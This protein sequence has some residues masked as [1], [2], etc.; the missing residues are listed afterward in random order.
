MNEIRS[1]FSAFVAVGLL[2]APPQVKSQQR[3]YRGTTQSV[4][5]LIHRIEDHTDL[6][7]NSVDAALAQN[8]LEASEE[9][10]INLRI[11][12]FD[13]SV[14]RLHERFDRRES[15]RT[16]AQEVLNRAAAIAGFMKRQPLDARTQRYWTSLRLD[17]NQ[18]ARTYGVAWPSADLSSMPPGGH[19]G[20]R[21]TGTYRLDPSKSDDPLDAIGRATQSLAG[22][23][24]QRIQDE[25]GP[26]LESPD[27]IALDL[28]G[29]SVTIAS[30]RAP[31]IN[32]TADGSE[33]L[34]TTSDGRSFRARATLNGG[35]L[36]VSSTSEGNNQFSV[37]FDSL[38]DGRRLGV[39]RRVY[40]EGLGR[41]VVV[42][43][44]YNRVSDLARFDIYSETQ[45]S[46]SPGSPS[47][48][49]IVRS[50][51]TI[52]AVLSDPLSTSTAREGDRFTAAVRE[53]AEYEGATIEGHVSNVQRSGRVTGRSQMTLNFDRIRLRDGRSYRFAGIVERARTSNGDTVQVDNEGSVKDDSQS[54]KT[55]QR[56]AIGTAVGAV[57][58]AIAGGGKGA[59]IGAVIGA[60]GGAGSVYV[61]GRDDLDLAKG[62]EIIIRA[63]GPK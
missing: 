8:A 24:R 60:G 42:Q 38:E 51:E 2:L 10:N 15:T 37:T 39:T 32:F 21:L 36:V 43:S 53:P 11:G 63:T 12:D 27:Q 17:L 5:Q 50:G 40:A 19:A 45:N 1:L 35:Q 46:A 62:S 55:V 13:D 47:A 41:P 23:E 44:T 58:G 3:L 25:V 16:D 28:R 6:Y 4:R 49:F 29:K 34:Q 9:D 54:K 59:A 56:A 26:P 52:A 33:H 30:S 48:D 61:Q 31:Q 7:R 22:S 14:K 20:A 57:I 18:L